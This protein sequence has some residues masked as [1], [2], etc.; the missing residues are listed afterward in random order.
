M[1][2]DGCVFNVGSF[3]D[4]RG[5]VWNLART[6]QKVILKAPFRIHITSEAESIGMLR[7]PCIRER[8][9]G[10]AVSWQAPEGDR[11]SPIGE[12]YVGGAS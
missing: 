1:F 9:D 7:I 8:R 12:A 4:Q 2:Q 5:A 3:K 10:V 6:R 11:Y